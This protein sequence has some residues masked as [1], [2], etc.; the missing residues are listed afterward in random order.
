MT[1]DCS[2]S[3]YGLADE[4]HGIIKNIAALPGDLL[5]I[6]V[7][8]QPAG[9]SAGSPD[10]LTILVS[11]DGLH[12]GNSK[13]LA[14]IDPAASRLRMRAAENSRAEPPR[15]LYAVRVGCLAGDTSESIDTRRRMP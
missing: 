7:V 3:R 13:R 8:L 6:I 10:D 11:E 2:D 14:H 15:T 9:N 4:P 1:I 12:S 5:N